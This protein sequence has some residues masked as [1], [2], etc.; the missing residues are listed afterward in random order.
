LSVIDAERIVQKIGDERR[1][2]N[3]KNIDFA[4]STQLKRP[5]QAQPTGV[6]ARRLCI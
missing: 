6:A 1:N 2:S 4:D 3:K 5:Q